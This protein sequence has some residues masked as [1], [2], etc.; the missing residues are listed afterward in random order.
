MCIVLSSSSTALIG[1]IIGG[2]ALWLTQTLYHLFINT[3]LRLSL[4]IDARIYDTSKLRM[5]LQ[6]I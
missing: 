2:L 6:K 1:E 4:E 5:I 3:L